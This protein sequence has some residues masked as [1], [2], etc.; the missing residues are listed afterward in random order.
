MRVRIRVGAF[1]GRAP[2]S[3]MVAVTKPFPVMATPVLRLE[4]VYILL[5]DAAYGWA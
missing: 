5:N 3:V 1:S 2:V 4:H